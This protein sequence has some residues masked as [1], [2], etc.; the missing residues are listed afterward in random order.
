[1]DNVLI[2]IIVPAY[3]IE[4][5][6]GRCLD[7][8]LEQQHQKLEVIVVDD[9]SVD[10]TGQI[11]DYYAQKDQRVISIH[12]ENGGVSSARLAGIERASGEYIGFIDGDD[13]IEPDMYTR[14][15]DNA[16]KYHAD[17]SHCGYQM[18]F[19]DH[20]DYYYNTG[21]IVEQDKI[22]GLKDL[23]SGVFVEPNLGN[24]LYHRKLFYHLI[25][26]SIIPKDIKINEDVLMNY[27]LFKLAGVSIYED[28]CSYH[29]ILRKGSA[30]TSRLNENKL[31]DPIRVTKIILQD[32]ADS[33]EV[34]RIAEERLITQMVG[35]SV[36]SVTEQSDLIKPYRKEIRAELR[37]KLTSVLSKPYIS[38]TT[39]IKAVWASI[40]PTSYRWV[41]TIYARITGIDRKYSIE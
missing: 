6:I 20:V 40:F 37:N 34:F 38:K 32:C 11:A 2:S 33:P 17:I 12:K 35:I 5:Y 28:F 13:Y 19:P 16:L 29:Y 9:G 39:K 18:V 22:T 8:I 7:S 36:L 26:E 14:L 15:L 1:M 21:R 41:H 24:K 25:N 4:A 23:L 30:A 31:K 10:R 3:N 27:W